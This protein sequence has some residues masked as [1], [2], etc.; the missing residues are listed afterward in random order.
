[1]TLSRT[2]LQIYR[3]FELLKF[4][5]KYA[6]MQE[7]ENHQKKVIKFW[8]SLRIKLILDKN[9]IEYVDDVEHINCILLDH[10]IAVTVLYGAANGEVV[11]VALDL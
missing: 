8:N 2:Y 1:M 4:E 10:H 3:D 5:Y 7:F 9:E 6:K 11:Q